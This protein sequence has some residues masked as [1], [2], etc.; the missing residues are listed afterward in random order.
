ML[1]SQNVARSDLASIAVS[2]LLREHGRSKSHIIDMAKQ[3]LSHLLNSPWQGQQIFE[4]PG[5]TD[6][7]WMVIPCTAKL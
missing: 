1:I 2:R 7:V 6:T 4:D 3:V 5:C